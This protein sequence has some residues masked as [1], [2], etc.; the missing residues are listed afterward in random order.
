M[1][2]NR[3]TPAVAILAVLAA[4]LAPAPGARAYDNKTVI[5]ST[6]I[7]Y[8]P[9]TTDAELV[10]T[11]T[12]IYNPGVSIEKVICPLPG[13]QQYDYNAADVSA[14][15]VYRVIGGA[16]GRVT[17]TLIQGSSSAHSEAVLTTTASGPLVAAGARAQFTVVGGEHNFSPMVQ[18]VCALSPKTSLAFI[19]FYEKEPTDVHPL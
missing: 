14:T 13:D 18:L 9:G 10:V 15:V 12:G 16:N 1:R 19:Y 6:C 2:P 5:P 7:A 3:T 11:P 17:C 4:G 8:G